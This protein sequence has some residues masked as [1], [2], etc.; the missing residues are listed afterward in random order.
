MRT[1]LSNPLKISDLAGTYEGTGQ[2]EINDSGEIVYKGEFALIPIGYY[3]RKIKHL[4]IRDNALII[5]IG[6]EDRPETPKEEK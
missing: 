5:S 6:W 2:A 3:S 4:Y 1:Y